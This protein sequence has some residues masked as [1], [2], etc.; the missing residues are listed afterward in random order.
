MYDRFLIS[1]QFKQEKCVLSS[2]EVETGKGRSKINKKITH[3][4]HSVEGRMSHTMEDYVFAQFK[5]VDG[6]ELGLFAVFDGHLS[7]EV[8]AY[9]RSHLF[10]N[11]I[12]EVKIVS[13]SY[14]I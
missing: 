12:N 9:L 2:D 3:G 10:D 8:P 7:Q 5:Q 4:H 6:N 11:I 14:N 1:Y 13:H